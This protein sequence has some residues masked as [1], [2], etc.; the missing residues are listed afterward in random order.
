MN[1]TMPA[2][3]R[4]ANATHIARLGD[5]ARWITTDPGSYETACNELREANGGSGIP[6]FEK[7]D[8]PKPAAP[9]SAPKPAAAALVTAPTP[10]TAPVVRGSTV[11][12]E[13]KA[14]SQADFD[15]AVAA[16]F[17]PAASLYERGTMVVDAG[18]DNARR[19]RV[20][21]D[22]LPLVVDYCRDFEN[23]IA[24]EER[25]DVKYPLGKV[26]MSASGKFA[27]GRGRFLVEDR[28]LSGIMT[29]FGV[30]GGSYLRDGCNAELRAINVNRQAVAFAERESKA[31]ENAKLAAEMAGEKIADFQPENVVLRTR[32]VLGTEHRS[33]FAAVSETFT[34]FDVDKIAQSIGMAVPKD[35]RGT[36]SYDGKRA[37]FEIVFHTNVQPEK[38]VSGEFF[39]AA[40]IVEAKDDGSGS[41]K[42]SA[43]VRQN[44]CLNLIVIDDARS[45]VGN[46]R[47]VGS[48]EK[49][50]ERFR[51]AF[52]E[53]LKKVG[54]FMERW[55][56]ACD[57]NALE[58]ALVA[59]GERAHDDEG[60]VNIREALPGLFDAIIE[61]ELVPV[62]AHGRKR[63]EVVGDLIAMYEKDESSATVGGFVSR[64]AVANAF[65]R[66]A[67]E[68]EGARFDPLA[69]TEIERAA[70]ALI[71]GNTKR[72][73]PWQEPAW[74][75]KAS[76]TANASA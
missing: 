24:A 64:A 31:Y 3:T 67:H 62:R 42:V 50:A 46:I 27:L 44:L 65:T 72:P 39:N 41:I 63:E 55:G 25:R 15:A 2:S 73:L 22:A 68:V 29:R 34:A 17:A 70:G 37:R 75:S 33:T 6:K 54:P 28:A 36:V 38:F 60:P 76:D 23:Q 14:R 12:A 26:R 52:A 59:A 18:V 49:L 45:K 19:A 11:S 48:V 58:A 57:D 56:Y 16:G 30:G 61:R 20:E 69:E 7:L 13:G 53:A 47:H 10:T 1:N 5:A 8:A 40:V 9:P 74:M 35:A 4:P 21:Y 66:Y 51:T 71:M 32:K 43:A